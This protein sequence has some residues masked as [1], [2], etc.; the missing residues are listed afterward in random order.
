MPVGSL[1]CRSCTPSP[2]AH[3]RVG[4]PRQALGVVLGSQRGRG[5]ITKV[6]WYQQHSAGSPITDVRGRGVEWE[7]ARHP[8]RG[9][10]SA[11]RPGA[12]TCWLKTTR[13]A[14]PHSERQL[15]CDFRPT[16]LPMGPARGLEPVP[17][18]RGMPGPAGREGRRRALSSRSCTSAVRSCGPSSSGWRA[19]P[20]TTTP[21]WVTRPAR[22]G[23]RP[24]GRGAGSQAAWASGFMASG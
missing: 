7:Q 19:M 12:F 13:L 18:A 21:P 17:R 3:P 22:H 15:P 1:R 2:T 24:G 10:L 16:A 23:G 14:L 11:R 5:S 4:G 8:R 20:P 9:A 6:P